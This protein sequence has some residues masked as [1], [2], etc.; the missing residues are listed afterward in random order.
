MIKSL[1]IF[2][3]LILS[4]IAL[5]LLLTYFIPSQIDIS[6]SKRIKASKEIVFIQLKNL[7]NW[8]NWHPWIIEDTGIELVYK[9]IDTCKNAS[10]MWNSEKIGEGDM[11][12]KKCVP[13]NYILMELNF[14][15][16]GK[17]ML[18]WNLKSVKNETELVCEVKT[19]P[20]K[21]PMLKYLF[22][23]KYKDRIE[24]VMQKGLENIGKKVSK[25]A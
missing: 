2:S 9:N 1:K 11:K 4:F 19:F 13:P 25:K 23:L 14:N 15:E 16:M 12:I 5:A 21:N 17:A 3:Y 7:K 8:E 10:L 22:L 24:A 18:I 20:T 6:K